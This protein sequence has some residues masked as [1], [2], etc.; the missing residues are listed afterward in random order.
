MLDPTQ[1]SQRAGSSAELWMGINKCFVLPQLTKRA[2]RGELPRGYFSAR[3]IR[4]LNNLGY[5]VPQLGSWPGAGRR[6]PPAPS[7]SSS[8]HCTLTLWISAQIST[9]FLLCR[10]EE[11]EG[12][13]RGGGG[14]YYGF[15][16]LHIAFSI[17]RCHPAPAQ[18][19][20]QPAQG[21]HWGCRWR[22]HTIHM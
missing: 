3:A 22:Y 2:W 6:L 7:L 12:R 20:L 10:L 21:Q 8:H 14:S 19:T 18:L 5:Q 4:A 1:E 9:D 13:G 17:L 15:Y 16:C 11:G